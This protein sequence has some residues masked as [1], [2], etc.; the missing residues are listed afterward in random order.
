MIFYLYLFI[1]GAAIG[2]FLN[3]VIDRLPFGKPLTGRSV[4][5]YC[6]KKLSYTELIPIFSFFY[7]KGKT[8]C[9]KKPLSPYY[10]LVE[11]TSAFSLPFVF[12]YFS[13]S[14]FWKKILVSLI[15]FSLIVI[16]FTDVKYMII[17]DEVQI[18]LLFISYLY[19]FSC[20]G[21]LFF[22]GAK[23]FVLG[24]FKGLILALPIASIF[25]LTRGKGI[26]FAD[27]KLA[28]NIGFLF[29]LKKGFLILYLAF[30]LGGVVAVLLLLA[31][32]K[33]LKSKIPFG[34]FLVIS[35][36]FFLFLQDKAVDL[37]LKFFL[38]ISP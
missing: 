28:F 11:L 16:F 21:N 37:L 17:P 1:L 27:V 5:D 7:L 33:G 10:P 14:I 36:L 6:G 24:V 35:M 20:T 13:D 26:G 38:L 29:G 2:S 3:V 15:V 34:P 32:K 9:C 8:A 31:R 22:C 23:L 4:C 18:F 25:Y 30:M 19:I 12:W